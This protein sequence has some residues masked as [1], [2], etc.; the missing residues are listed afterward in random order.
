M[1]MGGPPVQ[2]VFPAA[3]SLKG[4]QKLLHDDEMFLGVSPDDLEI[5]IEHS[6]E[7][8]RRTKWKAERVGNANRSIIDGH[9]EASFVSAKKIQVRMKT[10]AEMHIHV[11]IQVEGLLRGVGHDD[12]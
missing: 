11:A 7:P 9:Q 2:K 12:R 3:F 6:I 1:P 4:T 5:E 10:A 8:I